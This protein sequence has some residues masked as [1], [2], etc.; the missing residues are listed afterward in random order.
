MLKKIIIPFLIF[1]CAIIFFKFMLSSK[2]KTTDIAIDEHI[3][4]VNQIQVKKQLLSPS[5]TLYG[6]VESSELLNAAAPGASQVAKIL[7]KEGEYVKQG[8]LML[9]L[10]KADFEPIVQ[11]AQAKV[12]ELQALIKADALR[13]E[14][15]SSLLKNEK[16]LLTLSKKALARSEKI[17][18]QKLGSI[19]ETEQAMMQVEI[20]QLSYNKMLFS[21]REYDTRKEQLE[22]RLMQAH[23][24]LAKSNLTLQRSQIIAP[25]S[26]VVAKV[27]VAQGDRVNV[28]E[29]LLSFYSIEQLEIRAKIPVNSLFEIQQSM[30]HKQDL[31]GIASNGSQQVP[32][33][34]ERISGEAQASGIDAIF[35]IKSNQVHF[36]IGSIVVVR[37]KRAAQKNM[38]LVPYQAMYGSERLYQI[39]DE[40]LQLVTVK[41]IGEHYHSKINNQSDTQ[42][43]QLLITSD[44]LKSGDMILATHLP[45]AFT[46]LKVKIT[47]K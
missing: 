19:S 23:A 12:K 42:D 6:R 44:S 36:R 10:D 33:Q 1:A 4:R 13:H 25:F 30:T 24:D 14:V 8:Q 40:R 34:L 26:G 2:D 35:S 5:L 41:T 38:I 22:A 43:A 28:N 37:L 18:K 32:L 29:K 15:D 11:S 9:S 31:T 20:Q 46:G 45:N 16:R 3:W 39:K 17:K 21:V 7:V 27:N 47:S